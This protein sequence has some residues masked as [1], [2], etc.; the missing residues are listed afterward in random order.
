MKIGFLIGRFQPFHLGHLYLIK[1]SFDKVDK[2]IIGIGSPNKSDKDNPY[3]LKQRIVMLKKVINKEKLQN[4]IIKIIPIKDYPGDDDLWLIKTKKV[5][6]NF[7]VV[8]GNNEWV[9]GIF[10]KARYSVIRFGFFKRYLLEGVKIRRLMREGGEWQ[11]RVPDY[12]INQISPLRPS[13][14][15]FWTSWD[16]SGF[17][18]RAK[19]KFNHL[20]LGGTFDHFHKGHEKF[21][22]LGFQ[23]AKKVTI[24]ITQ[25]N[26]YKNKLFSSSVEDFIIRKKS[27]LDYLKKNKFTNRAKLITIKDV[28]GTSLTDQTIEGVV[29]T[30]ETRP[31]ALMINKIRKS[32]KLQPLKIII[33]PFIYDEEKK[34]ISSERIREGVIDRGGRVYFN[35][36]KN[37]KKLI[38]PDNLREDLRK[39]LGKAIEGGENELEETIKR[40]IKF[41]KL[42]RP[43][44]VIAVGDIV[45]ISLINVGFNPDISVVDFRSR[46][47]KIIL[48]DQY[49]FGSELP[50]DSLRSLGVKHPLRSQDLD[51][52][53]K[54]RND[55]GTINISAVIAIKKTIEKFLNSG[56]KQ[57][58][59]IAGEEDL[60]TLSAILLAPL[61][62]VVL[63]GQWNLGVV[64]VEVTEEKK[65]K[66]LDILRK[67]D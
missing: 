12:L 65:R 29:V 66:V 64:A 41:V 36:F 55:A 43:S 59:V 63:Y 38:L 13:H 26:L 48:R 53:E 54:V 49:L 60:L 32:R 1:K 3:S 47:K 50:L 21:L 6:G 10:E 15:V 27:V 34:I 23:A 30:K 2:L 35:I 5:A 18:G 56:K 40:V 16:K 67:F 58:L 20:I 11:E 39:P 51:H 62:S 14:F 46:R 45:A 57:T 8:I 42:V 61:G 17:V 28:F 7:D 25:K 9:N 44:M 24:G 52:F 37:K 31:N 22:D 4:K 33:A 19:F